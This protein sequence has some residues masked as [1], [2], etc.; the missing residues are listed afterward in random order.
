MCIN[1]IKASIKSM[2]KYSEQLNFD[3]EWFYFISSKNL[4]KMQLLI[5]QITIGRIIPEI[6]YFIQLTHV[7]FNSNASNAGTY[8]PLFSSVFTVV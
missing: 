2:G 1:H 3:V 4:K 7:F 6:L 5:L 8:L